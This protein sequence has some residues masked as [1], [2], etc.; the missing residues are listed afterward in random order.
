MS[1]TSPEV[2]RASQHVVAMVNNMTSSHTKLCAR[3]S[4]GKTTSAVIYVMNEQALKFRKSSDIH[5]RVPDLSD[6]MKPST[7]ML[8][9]ACS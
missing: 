6:T 8:H 3:L 7:V 1:I 2:I 4:L 5:G 9:T